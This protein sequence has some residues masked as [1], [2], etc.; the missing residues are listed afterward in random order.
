M[1]VIVNNIIIFFFYIM[2]SLPQIYIFM[3]YWFVFLTV[4]SALNLV[5]RL[6]TMLSGKPTSHHKALR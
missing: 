1:S 2:P 5:W 3:W 4:V 6:T